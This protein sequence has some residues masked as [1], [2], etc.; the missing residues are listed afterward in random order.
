MGIEYSVIDIYDELK[1]KYNDYLRPEIIS[2]NIIQTEDEVL[3]E[4]T[5]C[6]TVER[7]L[8]KQT[9]DRIDLG[10]ITD[11]ENEEKL[12][13]DPKDSI[14]K[15]AIKFIDDFTPY[16]IINTTDLFTEEAA[17]KICKKYNTFGV[18]K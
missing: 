17:N 5:E 16:S 12:F 2:I 11:G 13:F 14:E 4:T 15:N 9:V 6:I 10:F 18:Y 3:L 8:E 1:L 7:G